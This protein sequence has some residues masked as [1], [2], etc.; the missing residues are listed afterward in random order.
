MT[1]NLDPGQKLE[2]ITWKTAD[3]SSSLWILTSPR[4]THESPK[5]YTFKESSNLGLMEGVVYIQEQ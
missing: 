3:T 1:I 5:M 2:N 4:P